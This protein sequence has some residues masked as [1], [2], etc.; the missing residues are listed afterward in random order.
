L[1]PIVSYTRRSAGDRERRVAQEHLP[2]H[3]R[4]V[5]KEQLGQLVAQHGHPPPLGDIA[6][7]DEAPARL[8]DD[9]AHEPV[10]GEDAGDGG[11][12]RLDAPP[13]A[14]APRDELRADVLDLGD[15]AC[16]GLHVIRPQA[17][18]AAISEAGERPRG[19]SAEENDDPVAQSV[20]PL[21]GLPL[22]ADTEGQQHDHRHRAPGDPEDG[23]GGAELLRPQ[24]GEELA[25]HVR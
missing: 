11:R 1:R 13:H 8:G 5:T 7:V 10:H 12:G 20:K 2:P 22:Q 14:C 16:D 17:D 6:I 18:R 4:L 24:V 19:P 15:L 23:E 25:P 9:V 3:R 21:P